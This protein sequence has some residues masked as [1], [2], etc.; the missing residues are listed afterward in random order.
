MK[1]IYAV[2]AKIKLNKKP[3]WLDNYQKKY[4]NLYEFH[5]TLK[6]PCFIDESDLPNIKLIVPKV[7]DSFV[8]DNHKIEVVFK[9]IDAD[10]EDKSIMIS[11]EEN[12]ILMDLQYKIRTALKEYSNYRKQIQKEYETN[13]KPHLTIAMDLAD[14]FDDAVRDIGKDTKCVGEITE[15]IL[16]CVKENTVEEAKNP[17]NLTIY[18]L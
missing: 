14:K 11:A 2:W 6:Q 8:F 9:K 4:N 12:D 13:F 5:V 7:I 3:D 1:K 10:R 17:K 18:K 16:S 15:I